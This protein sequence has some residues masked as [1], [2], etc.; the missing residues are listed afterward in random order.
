MS[1]DERSRNVFVEK[2]KRAAGLSNKADKKHENAGK[3]WKKNVQ[4][5]GSRREIGRAAKRSRSSEWL[6]LVVM[7]F[8]FQLTQVQ[9]LRQ[10]SAV[11]KFLPEV[12][13]K[14]VIVQ[15]F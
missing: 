14:M 10:H 12:L 15:L 3:R 6:R 13:V 8:P 5:V 9:G 7:T 1:V 11:V 2:I 4:R